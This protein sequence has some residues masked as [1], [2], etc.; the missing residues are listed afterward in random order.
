V[1]FLVVRTRDIA[2][3]VVMAVDEARKAPRLVLSVLPLPRKAKVPHKN[4]RNRNRNRNS[5]N[6][7]NNNNSLIAKAV[8]GAVVVVAL[9]AD[10]VGVDSEV[11]SNRIRTRIPITVPGLGDQEDLTADH[12]VDLVDPT[13][14]TV[15]MDTVDTTD[16]TR[17]AS[18]SPTL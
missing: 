8:A 18:T 5:R 14:L 4:H 15:I 11:L 13:A 10:V 16:M 6:S 2:R 12:M 9:E 7:S 1:V 3:V 17:V